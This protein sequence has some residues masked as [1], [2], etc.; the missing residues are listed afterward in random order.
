VGGNLNA[1]AGNNL[2]MGAT[3]V[4]GNA[5]LAATQGNVAL[6]GATTTGGKPIRRQ[7]S[8]PLQ[9]RLPCRS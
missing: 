7:P 8:S 3:T 6:N 1:T 5:T 4:L 9:W 2:G